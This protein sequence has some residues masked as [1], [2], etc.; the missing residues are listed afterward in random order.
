MFE[1]FQTALKDYMKFLLSFMLR[2]PDMSE[3]KVIEEVRHN[4]WVDLGVRGTF[5]TYTDKKGVIIN[6][7]DLIPLRNKPMIKVSALIEDAHV[8]KKAFKRQKVT[9]SPELEAVNKD[10]FSVILSMHSALEEIDRVDEIVFPLLTVHSP[11]LN[12][13]DAKNNDKI[14]HY[15]R[16]TEKLIDQS[17]KSTKK[18]LGNMTTLMTIF[19]K[20]VDHLILDLKRKSFLMQ[21]EISM[22]EADNEDDEKASGSEDNTF[23]EDSK[24]LSAVES[25][26]EKFAS[27]QGEAKE[28]KQGEEDDE[29]SYGADED[30]ELPHGDEDGYQANDMAY[31]SVEI[32]DG[33]MRQELYFLRGMVWK[34]L[35]SVDNEYDFGLVHLDCSKFKERILKHTRDLIHHLE[36]H[37]RND[38]LHKLKNIQGEIISIKGKLD[39][40]VESIDD[41]IMLLDYIESLKKQDNKIGDIAYMIS[42]L[43]K[44]MEYLDNIEIIF[45]GDQYY[46]FLHIRN[47]PYT[48]KTYIEERKADLLSKKDGLYQEMSNEIGEIFDQ[49]KDFKSTIAEILGMGL[50]PYDK[51]VEDA[52]I[53]SSNRV[54]TLNVKPQQSE[55]ET[56]GPLDLEQEAKRKEEEKRL[57]AFG[58]TFFW[59]A[60]EIGMPTRSFDAV[61]NYKIFTKTQNLK[62]EFDEVERATSLINK[63]E[64]LLGVEQTEF[65]DLKIIQDDLKPLYELWLVASN[66]GQILPSWVEDK[67]DAV[68]SMYVDLKTEEWLNELKRLQKT[69]LVEENPK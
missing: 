62:Q 24:P 47:W 41:V 56:S 66:F 69:Q 15:V 52:L 12:I 10:L 32:D 14:S 26:G 42:E 3:T 16:L 60:R 21:Q 65:S 54:S 13:P 5:N 39:M 53:N 31:K 44:R 61:Q 36:G 34:I 4:D 40:E 58:K 48:F 20:K 33:L 63:R 2:E 38:F 22:A 35:E 51:K 7:V 55:N 18:E 57:D 27:N 67:F 49:I 28:G 1:H 46:E 8:G 50:V 37:N 17:L 45:P 59:L 23:V 30:D 43:A 6:N 19:D 68:D 25:L 11:M 29:E 64:K 9:T